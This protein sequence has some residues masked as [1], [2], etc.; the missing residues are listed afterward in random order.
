M[1]LLNRKEMVLRSE[2]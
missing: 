2:Y 1:V